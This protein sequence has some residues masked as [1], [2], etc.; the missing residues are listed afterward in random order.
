MQEGRPELALMH[1]GTKAQR[2]NGGCRATILHS[3][4]QLAVE[5]LCDVTLTSSFYQACGRV[6][7]AMGP[8]GDVGN[9]GGTLAL[10]PK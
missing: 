10:I 1:I 2:A 6:C 3:H 4:Q 9:A 8:L 7:T 5:G